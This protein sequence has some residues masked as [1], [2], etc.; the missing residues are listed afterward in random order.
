MS[1]KKT[2]LLVEDE[3]GVA[4]VIKTKLEA[5][6]HQM[7]IASDGLEGYNLAHSIKPDL[8]ILDIMIPRID[9]IKLCALLKKDQRFTNTPI[10][11]LSAQAN[12]ENIALS[13]KA[14]ATDYLTKPFCLEDLLK[15]V[16]SLLKIE[17]KNVPL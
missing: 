15:K 1:T 11:I 12:E 6:S 4:G 9:G 8:I 16:Q 2:I 13:K 7:L 3:A 14:G 17:E 5:L 10:L